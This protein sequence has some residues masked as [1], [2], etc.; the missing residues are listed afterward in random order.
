MLRSLVHIL[1]RDDGHIVVLRRSAGKGLHFGDEVS[2]S[3]PAARSWAAALLDG[4]RSTLETEDLSA[5]VAGFD[6]AVR[7]EDD[8]IAGLQHPFYGRIARIGSNARV[9]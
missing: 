6:D 3:A 8:A 1:Q 4:C 7:S 5:F 9:R 2:T